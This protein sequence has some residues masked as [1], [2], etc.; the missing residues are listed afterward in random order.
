MKII[1]LG[2]NDKAFYALFVHLTSICE[3]IRDL[4]MPYKTSLI[5]I[6]ISKNKHETS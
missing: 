2:N 1:W 3:M 5:S 4:V 6:H